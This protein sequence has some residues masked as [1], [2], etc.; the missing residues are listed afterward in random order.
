MFII[1][2]ETNAVSHIEPELHVV[3]DVFT[4]PRQQNRK[5]SKLVFRV[6][7]K[8]R[9]QKN[10]RRVDV[11]EEGGKKTEKFHRQEEEAEKSKVL[12]H[13]RGKREGNQ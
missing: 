1:N 7:A 5:A 2:D 12:L 4:R 11:D 3:L 9:I 8:L 10:R 6:K 13:N